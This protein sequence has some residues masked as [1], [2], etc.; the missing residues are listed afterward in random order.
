TN[1]CAAPVQALETVKLSANWMAAA[2]HPARTR[3]CTTRSAPSAWRCALRS[4]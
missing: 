1:L 3:C 4:A 2:G